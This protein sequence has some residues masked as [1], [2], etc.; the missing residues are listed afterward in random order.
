LLEHFKQ[1]ITSLTLI[2]AD[3]GKFEVFVDGKEI[4]SKLKTGSFPASQ[5]VIGALE[6][7]R[8]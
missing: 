1:E 3:K 5:E 4:H 7:K 8:K 2:P 6:G